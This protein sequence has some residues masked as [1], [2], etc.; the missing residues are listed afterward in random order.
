MSEEKT[1][2]EL[3]REILRDF[4]KFLKERNLY[5]KYK[6]NLANSVIKTRCPFSSRNT[7]LKLWYDAFQ[8]GIQV[9]ILSISTVPYLDY[10]K[11]YSLIDYAFAWSDTPQ[12]HNFWRE[13]NNEWTTFFADKYKQ[14]VSILNE[15]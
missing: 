1:V 9:K 6:S 15:K 7:Q 13:I 14:Y 4:T 8:Y 5:I 12:R 11:C 10:I 2:K 3:R